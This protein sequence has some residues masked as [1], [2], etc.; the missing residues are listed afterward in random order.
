MTAKS[1]QEP[2][3]KGHG[4]AKWKGC[5]VSERL[6][7]TGFG[8]RRFNEPGKA[9]QPFQGQ[10]HCSGRH[11]LQTMCCW[12][13]ERDWVAVARGGELWGRDPAAA[14]GSIH[15]TMP[16]HGER[17]PDLLSLIHRERARGGG[18]G[19]PMGVSL[20][21]LCCPLRCSW[22]FPLCQHGGSSLHREGAF[23]HHAH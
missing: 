20:C 8:L 16:G 19:A 13:G 17:G 15:P 10:S 12:Q 6:E 22:L 21:V 4:E 7:G 1:Q 18:E 2:L 11:T 14:F 3:G 23:V 5:Q 9:N